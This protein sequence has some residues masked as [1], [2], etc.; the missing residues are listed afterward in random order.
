[1]MRREDSFFLN[2]TAPDKEQRTD[3]IFRKISMTDLCKSMGCEKCLLRNIARGIPDGKNIWISAGY[4]G[5]YRVYKWSDG[6]T[7]IS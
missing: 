4:G 6:K 5:L 7:E 1:M 3:T 2:R